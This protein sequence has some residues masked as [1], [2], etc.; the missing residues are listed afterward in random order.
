M[1]GKKILLRKSMIIFRIISLGD[2]RISSEERI[3]YEAYFQQ[4]GPVQGYLSGKIFKRY[5]FK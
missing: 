4:C 1:A 3:R 5:S 2:W